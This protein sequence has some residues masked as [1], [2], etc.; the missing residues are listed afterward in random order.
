MMPGWHCSLVD[1]TCVLSIAVSGTDYKTGISGKSVPCTQRTLIPLC[2]ANLHP[3]T[4]V[5]VRSE[6]I[7][8]GQRSENI[9]E[10]TGLKVLVPFLAPYGRELETGLRNDLYGHEGGN[11]GYRQG[12]S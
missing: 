3:Q 11:L 5:T 12:W 4:R 1:F 8:G 9:C 10:W 2:L 7:C 6:N